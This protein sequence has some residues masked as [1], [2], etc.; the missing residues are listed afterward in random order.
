MQF[1]LCASLA[2]RQLKYNN[3]KHRHQ[4]SMIEIVKP[5]VDKLNYRCLT[6]DNGIRITLI[7]D[8]DADKAAAAMDVS[9]VL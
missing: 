1:D 9:V 6:L 8:A 7:S 3:M 5:A 2:L 4:S